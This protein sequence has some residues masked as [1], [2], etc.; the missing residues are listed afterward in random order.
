[1][2]N[3]RGTFILLF[4]FLVVVSYLFL[5]DNPRV[6]R[7]TE[8]KEKAEKLFD[9][10][11]D[12]V[13][14]AEIVSSTGHFLISKNADGKWMVKNL[15]GEPSVNVLADRNVV[16]K[17]VQE[18]HEVK[19]TRVVD[20]KGDDLAGFGF[21]SPEKSVAL[22]LKD[23][24]KLKLLI[25]DEAPLAQSLYLKRGDNAK[26]Y[27]S[28]SGIR[29]LVNYEFWNLRNKHL[30]SYDQMS[31]DHVE[32]KMPDRGWELIKKGDEWTFQDKP[33]EK[34]NEEKLSAFLFQAG[35]LD[36]EKVLSE[37]G[38]DLK[39]YGLDPPA[40]TLIFHI[41]DQVHTLLVGKA[42]KDQKVAALG[43]TAGPIFEIKEDFLNRIPTREELVKKEPPPA[44]AVTSGMIKT[45]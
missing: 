33:G 16:D 31:I 17:I 37:T 12:Q 32:V 3:S 2:R 11:P 15:Q 35:T 6:K 19:P 30:L 13:Q 42:N 34:V 23:G 28:D 20:E 26:V 14:Q 21:K 4:F 18:M 29:L 9:F 25:G 5:F 44:P 40:A 38:T 45:K 43:N 24:M 10:A 36:G 39:T 27:L 7:E 41:K 8:K 1:M 22:T